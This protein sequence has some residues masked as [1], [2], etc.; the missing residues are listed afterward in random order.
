[1]KG[2]VA[3]C[4]KIL[5]SLLISQIFFNETYCSNNG[6]KYSNMINNT[7][8]Q[9]G[10]RKHLSLTLGERVYSHKLSQKQSGNTYQVL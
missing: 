2:F 6:K 5:Y 1:M 8:C 3:I 10:V 7:Q 4:F 9:K